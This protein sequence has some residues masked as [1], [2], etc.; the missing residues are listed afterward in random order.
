MTFIAT[1]E[2]ILRPFSIGSVRKC[3]GAFLREEKFNLFKADFRAITAVIH[4]V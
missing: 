3:P 1:L 2:S 4:L